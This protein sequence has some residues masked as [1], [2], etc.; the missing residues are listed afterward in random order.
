MN[1]RLYSRDKRRIRALE[2]IKQTIEAEKERDENGVPVTNINVELSR[3]NRITNR[4]PLEPLAFKEK[5]K[6]KEELMYENEPLVK[7]S[8]AKRT[9][10]R[11]IAEKQI[12]QKQKE[13][14]ANRIG[15]IPDYERIPLSKP[16]KLSI[17]PKKPLK[18]MG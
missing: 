17:L 8:D 14:Y 2:K 5:K 18:K 12:I 1:E 15:Y 7:S 9:N 13:M 3:R 16:K 11:K 6:E 4:R 10:D